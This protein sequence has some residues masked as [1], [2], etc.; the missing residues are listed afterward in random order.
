MQ[1]KLQL[2]L[3]MAAERKCTYEAKPD[4]AFDQPFRGSL[5]LE[6]QRS[7]CEGDLGGC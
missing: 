6:Q 3:A 1:G 4:E 5:R 2:T 7:L